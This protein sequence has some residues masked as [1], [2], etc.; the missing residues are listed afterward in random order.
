M[1]RYQLLTFAKQLAL[2]RKEL[3][4]FEKVKWPEDETGFWL[5]YIRQKF[6]IINPFKTNFPLDIF[7][8][9]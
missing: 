3:E 2:R 5:I 1:S 9:K 6:K 4:E 8:R 7:K